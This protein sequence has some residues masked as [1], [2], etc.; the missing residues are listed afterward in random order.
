M[1]WMHS[2]PV[3]TDAFLFPPSPLLWVSTKTNKSNVLFLPAHRI[4]MTPVENDCRPP[5][6]ARQR[7]ERGLFGEYA[8][9]LSSS[10]PA[11]RSV[12]L[13]TSL[14]IRHVILQVLIKTSEGGE[15]GG[16]APG[17]GGGG[18][19]GRGGRGGGG[20]EGEEEGRRGGGEGEEERRGGGA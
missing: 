14:V 10:A 20:E 12:R 16:K 5:T 18:G 9:L 19:G 17:G 11:R 7:R 1:H 6:L 3:L 8:R 15:D 4:E 2:M 13:K